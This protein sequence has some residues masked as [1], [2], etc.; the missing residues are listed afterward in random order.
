MAEVDIAVEVCRYKKWVN[1]SMYLQIPTSMLVVA[2]TSDRM[3]EVMTFWA[4]NFK[5]IVPERV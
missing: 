3:A 5:W 1:C 4:D 2:L